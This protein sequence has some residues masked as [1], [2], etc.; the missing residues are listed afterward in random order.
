MKK[1]TK[2]LAVVV[3]AAAVFLV[4]N[5]AKAASYADVA[6]V[7]DQSGSMY[8][9]FGWIGSS[10]SAI[11]T[12]IAGAGITAKY[13][14]AGYEYYAGSADSRNAWVDIVSGIGG[15]VTE[16]GLVSTYGGTERGYHALDWAANNFSW[17]GGDY[18]KVVIL[19]T[20]EPNDQR[21]SYAY[22]TSPTLYGEP[23][24][25]QMISD[26]DILLNVITQTYNYQYWDGAVY[27]TATYQG[28]FDLNDLRYNTAEFTE[29]FTD[30]KI[31]EIE[32]YNPN[33]IPEPATMLLLGSGFFGLIGLRRKK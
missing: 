11:D 8:G 19:I 27:S 32:E 6:F 14:I 33:G 22:G 20:D 4:P 30:A 31:A 13:G 29:D 12:A 7:I 21:S 24:L 5:Q 23:A 28:L 17:T 2:V 26:N 16:V 15:V 1:V 3:L 25:A 10:L 9:E 18:A